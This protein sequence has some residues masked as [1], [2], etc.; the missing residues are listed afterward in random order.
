MRNEFEDVSLIFILPLLSTILNFLPILPALQENKIKIIFHLSLN[1]NLKE[2]L[3]GERIR[4]YWGT[5]L[6]MEIPAKWTSVM[7]SQD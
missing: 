6:W 5:Y 1:M 2:I 7:R 4:G 3:D